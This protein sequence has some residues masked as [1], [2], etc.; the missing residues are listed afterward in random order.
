VWRQLIYHMPPN[1]EATMAGHKVRIKRIL[2]GKTYNTETATLLASW[3]SADCPDTARGPERGE[4]LFQTR[5]GAYFLFQFNE[6]RDPW[7]SGHQEIVPLGPGQA[8]RWAETYC[9][10]DIIEAIFGVMPEA[11]DAEAKVTLRMPDIL[12]RRLAAMAEAQGQSMNATI[13]R[14]LERCVAAASANPS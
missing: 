3:S 1:C 7:E 5:H 4:M 14:C 13:V 11:G 9:S 12:R 8:R 6:D 10:A 2:D